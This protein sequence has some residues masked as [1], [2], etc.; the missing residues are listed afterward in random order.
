[1]SGIVK[2][3]VAEYARGGRPSP[4]RALVAAAAA[5]ATVASLTYRI[6]RR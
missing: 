1:V 2:S 6:L 5:G 4:I 3:A